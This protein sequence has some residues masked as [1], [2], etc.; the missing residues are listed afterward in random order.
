MPACPHWLISLLVNPSDDA[1]LDL[2]ETFCTI[3]ASPPSAGG[4][5]CPEAG[6]L[7]DD[8]RFSA[9]KERDD[10]LLYRHDIAGPTPRSDR[11]YG[12]SSQGGGRS[13]EHTSELQSIMS[14]S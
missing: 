7:A 1:T 9:T 5:A 12:G 4:L 8:M 13:E 6:T 14:I 3:A 2:F 11:A 10:E